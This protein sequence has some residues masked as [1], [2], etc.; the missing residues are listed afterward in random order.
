[1]YDNLRVQMKIY[2]DDETVTAE[3]FLGLLNGNRDLPFPLSLFFHRSCLLSN[4][5]LPN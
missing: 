5:Q 2:L 4:V 3:N 1:M